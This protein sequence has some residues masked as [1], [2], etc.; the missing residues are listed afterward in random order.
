[1]TLL[2]ILSS[3]CRRTNNSLQFTNYSSNIALERKLFNS[4]S[5]VSTIWIPELKKDITRKEKGNKSVSLIIIDTKIL[6]K[7][8]ANHIWHYFKKGLYTINKCDLSQECE[9]D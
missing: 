1:M 8:M 9:V 2:K 5:D 4:V 3:I 6:S 7:I